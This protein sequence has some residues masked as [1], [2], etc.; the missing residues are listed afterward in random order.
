MYLFPA[1]ALDRATMRAWVQVP[2]YRLAVVQYR[3]DRDR[4]S[5]ILQYVLTITVLMLCVWMFCSSKE[6]RTRANRVI[7][8][9]RPEDRNASQPPSHIATVH[10]VRTHAHKLTNLA[11]QTCQT[12]KSTC[13]H[14][15]T[16]FYTNQPVMMNAAKSSS[17]SLDSSWPLAFALAKLTP[18][19]NQAN[20]RNGATEEA[21]KRGHGR[22]PG[23]WTTSITRE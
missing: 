13:V 8:S 12:Y 21:L 11:R 18:Q 14:P 10:T 6:V 15:H 4:D 9:T 5:Y 7:P 17:R 20:T 16:Q 3:R 22:A 2:F 19:D 23:P 1:N